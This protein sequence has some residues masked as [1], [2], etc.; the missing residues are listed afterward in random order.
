MDN[1][2]CIDVPGYDK[3]DMHAAARFIG[4]MNYGYAGTKELNEALVSRFMVID[5]PAQDEET[6]E[7]ILKR[8]FP[9]MKNSALKQWI[10]LFMDL[11]LKAYNSEI[12]TKSLDLR[13]MIGALKTIEE[14]LKPGLAVKMGVVNKCFDMFE[15][16]IV[17]D[18][19]MTRIPDSWTRE[20]VFEG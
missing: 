7:F 8:K 19:V 1:R 12:T 11:Q 15:K 4:T 14:G 17:Q 20:D 5:M 2:R 10:G 13:G 16:E 9:K 3:I 18:V 6:L